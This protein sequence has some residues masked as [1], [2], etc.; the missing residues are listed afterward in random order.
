MSFL[1]L[2]L[3]PWMFLNKKKE[4][5]EKCEI[6]TNGMPVMIN[7]LYL[8]KCPLWSSNA[9]TTLS[10]YTSDKLYRKGSIIIPQQNADNMLDMIIK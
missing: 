8:F 6:P 7:G 1:S 4:Y 10:L 9:F 2:L 5:E 3:Y